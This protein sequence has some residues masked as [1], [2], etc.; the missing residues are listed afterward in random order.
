VENIRFIITSQLPKESQLLI[1]QLFAD[2]SAVKHELT[3]S[4][5]PYNAIDNFR[6]KWSTLL[7]NKGAKLIRI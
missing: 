6:N 1:T 2:A 4:D 3:T 5:T 7:E